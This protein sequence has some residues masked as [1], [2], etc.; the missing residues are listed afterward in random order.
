MLGKWG[1]FQEIV[2]AKLHRLNWVFKTSFNSKVISMIW[3]NLLLFEKLHDSRLK[4]R[5]QYRKCNKNSQGNFWR[6][7]R[8]KIN[9]SF[10][11]IWRRQWWDWSSF[12]QWSF[13]CR[14]SIKR[15]FLKQRWDLLWHLFSL[16]NLNCWWD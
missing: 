6:L 1:R 4:W 2:H 7:R 3:E 16:C 14:P 11:W 12:F 5:D 9:N 13:P 8:R 10:I 15:S